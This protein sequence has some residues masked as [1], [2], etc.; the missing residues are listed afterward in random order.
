MTCST[1]SSPASPWESWIT[2]LVASSGAMWQWM[3]TLTLIAFAVPA[4]ASMSGCSRTV[5]VEEGS[6]IRTGPQVLTRVYVLID[7]EWV[8]SPDRVAIP[9]GWYLVPP[10]FVGRK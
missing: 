5:L 10:S 4:I 7:G 8:L 1:G 2:W 3:P 9:E 6:P